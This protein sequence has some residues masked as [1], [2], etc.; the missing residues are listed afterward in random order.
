VLHVLD[1]FTGGRDAGRP[2][3]GGPG[4]CKWLA[5]DATNFNVILEQVGGCRDTDLPPTSTASETLIGSYWMYP[6]LKIPLVGSAC[7][8]LL[9]Q[10]GDCQLSAAGG[11]HSLG[12]RH[13]VVRSAHRATDSELSSGLGPV[14]HQSVGGGEESQS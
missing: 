12:V 1:G 11:S 10:V 3:A 6:F 5:F 8:V 13:Q 9:E 4:K 2:G 14:K 7:N